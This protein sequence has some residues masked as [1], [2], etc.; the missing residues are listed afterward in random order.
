MNLKSFQHQ[1]LSLKY[2]TEDE[3]QTSGPERLLQWITQL[4]GYF[5][6]NPI[7]TLARMKPQDKPVNFKSLLMLFPF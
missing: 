1:I 6:A 3:K 4:E 7:N 2:C 5:F